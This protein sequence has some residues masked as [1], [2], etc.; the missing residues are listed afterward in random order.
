[1]DKAMLLPFFKATFPAGEPL[2]LF[3]LVACSTS[4]NF[5]PGHSYTFT[6]ADMAQELIMLQLH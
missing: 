3:F 1:M 2:A 6:L 4:G 5:S